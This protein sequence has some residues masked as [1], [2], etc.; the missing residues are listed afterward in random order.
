MKQEQLDKLKALHEAA[1]PDGWHVVKY[2]D[3]DSLVICLD[4]AGDQRIAFM[5][6]P[7]CRD[8]IKRQSIWSEIKANAALIVALRNA[9]P[10]L[11]AQAE[12]ANALEAALRPF[13]QALDDWGDE[14]E[15]PDNTNAWEHPISL[16]LTI[17]DFRRAHAAL[18][19]KDPAQ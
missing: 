18:E 5:A 15:Q 12:R 11:I 4:V 6:T 3:G 14:A 8:S 19:Q 17:G 1:T 10:D 2:G 13:A 9:L 7:G 16:D